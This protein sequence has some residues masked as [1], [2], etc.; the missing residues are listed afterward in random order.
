MTDHPQKK[1]QPADPAELRRRAEER[2][3]RQK[4]EGGGQRTELETARLFHELQVHQIE[5][6][7]QNEELRQ[8]RAQEAAFTARYIDLY[9]FAPVGYLTLDREGAMRQL[10]LSGA[11]LLGLER[12][13]LL[14]RR[15]GQFVAEG[16]HRAFSDFLQKVFAS[17]VK[18]CCEVTLPQAGPHPFFVRIE[19]ARS[20]DGQECLAALVDLTERHQA[21]A[22]ARAT[23]AEAQRLLALADQSRLALL[24]TAEDEREAAEALALQT[25]ITTLFLTISDD[26]MF[27][28]VLEIILDVMHSPSGVFGFID[29][30]GALVVPTTP[31]P[32]RD[33]C[34]VPE[35][36]IR[37]PQETWVDSSWPR[38]LREK[39]TIHSNEP[40]ANVPEGHVGI[41]RHISMPI[42]FQGEAIGL[43]QVANK[44]TDYAEADLRTLE[45]IA[46]H[47]APLLRAR[48]RRERAQKA[49]RTLNAELEQRVAERTAQFEAANQELE[50]FSYSISH[51]LR[52]PLRAIDGFARILDE[53]YTARLDDEGRRVLGTI[54][55]EARRMGQLIDDLLAFSRMSRQHVEPAQID[56]TALAQAV[57]DECA[58]QAPGRQ[59]QFKVQPLPPAQGD[60]AM[61]RQVLANLISNA[62]KYTRP[63]TVAEI[64]IGGRTEGGENLY[65]VKDNGV[66]F[67]MKHA[68]KLF[69]V[70]QR[71]HSEAEFEGTGVGLA[72]VQR[73]IHRHGGRVWAEGKLN[74]GAVF[75]FTLKG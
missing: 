18:E 46:G 59:L 58:A 25:R 10:N 22:Q 39:R 26:Q 51:D 35:K 14:K 64:E 8:V 30:D 53:D 29:Q 44:A 55:G 56:M 20:A 28:G 37:F 19:A 12:S 4:P 43:F 16:D 49:L 68:G 13:R 24:S 34:Q 33:K 5:L 36:M 74:E 75:Y 69:G 62:I 63:R 42:L 11:R 67:D 31:R 66:G 40:S 47:V 41:Q 71:L 72:L 70:F 3:E 45:A 1:T 6:E 48:L 32:I 61:L 23:Q 50:A 27:N 52:A 2:L 60:H 15:F 21:E 9:D 7:M 54:C 73:V 38:A 17:E 65:Y 57:F